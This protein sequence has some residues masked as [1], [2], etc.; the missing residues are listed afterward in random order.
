VRVEP[1]RY[2]GRLDHDRAAVEALSLAR[3]ASADRP[4]AVTT[5]ERAAR[6]AFRAFSQSVLGLGAREEPALTIDAK[7]RGH[8]LHALVEAGQL[9]LRASR[10]AGARAQLAAVADALDEAGRAF[11]AG[12]PH[13]DPD[14]L[15]ADVLAIRRQVEAYLQRRM[16]AQD[17]WDLVAT[18]VAFGPDEAWP[19]LEVPVDGQAPIVL[20]GR[21]DGVERMD[22][23]LRV[24][25]FKSGRGDGFRKRLREGVLDTQFQLVVYAAALARA[26]DEGRVSAPKATIDGVYVGFRDQS[27]H[28]LREALEGRGKRTADEPVIRVEDVVRRG[29]RGEGALGEAVRRAVVPIRQGLFAP[30]P[31]DCEFCDASALCRVERYD[32]GADE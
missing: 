28:T 24:V 7:G 16:D 12:E 14:L 15:R 18:E 9:A 5:L 20:Q 11:A 10:G 17:R 8:L 22:D 23:A 19:A 29:A 31:R 1:G 21:I 30:R 3:W 2:S 13:A 4:L 6:C 26:A 27:E 25:E 32:G